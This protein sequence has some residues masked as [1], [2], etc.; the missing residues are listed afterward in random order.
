MA[1]EAAD[2]SRKEAVKLSETAEIERTNAANARMFTKS[3]YLRNQSASYYHLST[4]IG[5][6]VL[7]DSQQLWSIHENLFFIL[8]SLDRMFVIQFC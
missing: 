8:R 7:Q 2:D 4:L 6:Q 3:Q 5:I 1:Q